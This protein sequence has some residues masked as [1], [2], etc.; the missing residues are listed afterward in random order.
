MGR[1]LEDGKRKAVP[2][3]STELFLEIE[4]GLVHV[5]QRKVCNQMVLR[6]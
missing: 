1:R 6:R 3:L 2:S 4:E 5:E